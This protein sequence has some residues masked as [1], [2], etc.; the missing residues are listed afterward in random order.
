MEMETNSSLPFLEVFIKKNQSQS[1]HHSVYRKPTYTTRYL[2]A[3]S[4]YTPS[5]INSVIITLVSRLIHLYDDGSRST[6]LFC[7]KQA[8][9][10]N[11]YC[12]NHTNRSTHRDSDS[13]HTKA[14]PPYSKG[15]T[16]K[17]D[18]ILK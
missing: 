15:V 16:N 14:F 17:I 11:G 8:P 5:Q 7:L 1:F 3:N 2:H 18:K 10:Q 6:E 4:H 13:H 12:E 9:I